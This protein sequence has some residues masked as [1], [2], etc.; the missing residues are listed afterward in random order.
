MKTIIAGYISGE[1]GDK[2]INKWLEE[3][4]VSWDGGDGSIDIWQHLG[5]ETQAQYDSWVKNP[6]FLATL[7]K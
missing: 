4:I 6:N 3:E 5:F 2:Y 7:K 1:I